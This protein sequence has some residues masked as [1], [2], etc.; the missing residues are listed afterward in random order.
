MSPEAAVREPLTSLDTRFSEPDAKPTSWPETLAA[1][2]AAELFWITTVRDDGRPHVS[3]VVAVWL[4]DALHFAT[5]P[6]EQKA[7]NLGGNPQVTLITGCN[8]WDQ[9]LDLVVEG[10]A[11]RVTDDDTLKRLAEAWTSKWDGR[12]HYEVGNGSLQHP[13]GGTALVYAVRPTNVLAFAKGTFT[14]TR[15]RFAP[16][17]PTALG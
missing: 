4:D 8:N 7:V 2:E 3:P 15:H 9:G 5:G 13:G 1:I 11:V 14:H 17:A 10:E 16:P 6:E 12:W